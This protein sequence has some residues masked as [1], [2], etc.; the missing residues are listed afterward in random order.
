MDEIGGGSDYAQVEIAIA[1]E[2]LGIAKF[3]DP[4]GMSGEFAVGE[5]TIGLA[6]R[7]CGDLIDRGYKYRLSRG[8]LL[9]PASL[10]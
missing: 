10:S 8:G 5:D 7:I 6:S 2:H 3:F 1:L 4:V 9:R